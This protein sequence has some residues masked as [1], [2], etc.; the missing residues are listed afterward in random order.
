M[1][2]ASSLNFLNDNIFVKLDIGL[3]EFLVCIFLPKFIV[4]DGILN[5]P[6]A[7]HK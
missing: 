2:L 4:Y 3:S 7:L 5:E 6:S 1:S